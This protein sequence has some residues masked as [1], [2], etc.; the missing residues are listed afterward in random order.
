MFQLFKLSA[1][2]YFNVILSIAIFFLIFIRLPVNQFSLFVVITTTNNLI[3][4]L[5]SY[6]INSDFLVVSKLKESLPIFPLRRLYLFSLITLTNFILL[7]ITFRNYST[8]NN[9]LVLSLLSSSVL[10]FD[11]VVV[12][13]EQILIAKSQIDLSI[14]SKIIGQFFILLFVFIGLSVKPNIY[15]VLLSKLVFRII[16]SLYFFVKFYSKRRSYLEIRNLQNKILG[17]H[18]L[19]K[20]LRVSLPIYLIFQ[21]GYSDTDIAII[22]LAIGIWNI[23]TIFMRMGNQLL[24]VEFSNIKKEI[25]NYPIKHLFISQMI[26][27]MALFP[28]ASF[29]LSYIVPLISYKYNEAG[30]SLYL[31]G[32]AY[33]WL[34]L[35]LI[36]RSLILSPHYHEKQVSITTT[37]AIGTLIILITNFYILLNFDKTQNTVILLIILTN[38]FWSLFHILIIKNEIGK[39]LSMSL[40]IILLVESVFYYNSYSIIY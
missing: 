12:Y 17:I 40:P 30:Y 18:L 37:Y 26:I 15:G 21:F 27:S 36:P 2:Q 20:Y 1:G 33:L 16:H 4:W 7:S 24:I 13:C 3:G 5:F 22:G 28:I 9:I 39:L 6:F 8:W 29:I 10:L 31:L 14:Y 34:S 38:I 23:V 11:N 25:E 32:I 35:D 19:S